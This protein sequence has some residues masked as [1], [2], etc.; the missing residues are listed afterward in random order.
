M[1][2][3][4]LENAWEYVIKKEKEKIS[5]P[6]QTEE[7][8]NNQKISKELITN[9]NSLAKNKRQDKQGLRNVKRSN[10]NKLK[11]SDL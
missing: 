7:N 2:K 6:I 1:S 11:S 5:E 10:T 3:N 9:E 4:I 8:I